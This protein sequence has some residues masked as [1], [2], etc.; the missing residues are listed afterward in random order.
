[1]SV[2]ADMQ[3]DTRR[4]QCPH[5]L[6]ALLLGRQR[7]CMPTENTAS[8]LIHRGLHLELRGLD[9][10]FRILRP[11]TGE[12]LLL[13]E[14]RPSMERALGETRPALSGGSSQTGAEAWRAEAP[15]PG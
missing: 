8:A 10:L 13:T 12:K 1:M 7:A 5:S 15:W 11:F 14:R 4:S 3:F 6:D 2:D 9:S